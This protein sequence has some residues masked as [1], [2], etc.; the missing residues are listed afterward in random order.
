MKYLF[1]D[2]ENQGIIFVDNVRELNSVNGLT[3]KKLLIIKTNFTDINKIKNF[4]RSHPNIDVWIATED[5]SRQNIL[6]ANACGIKNVIEYPIKQEILNDILKEKNEKFLPDKEKDKNKYLAVKGLK[7]MIVDDNPLNTE[8]LE[9]TLKE[10][11]LNLVT[12]KKSK[13]A[14][15][16]I[17][18]EKF[19]LFMLDIMMPEISGFDLAE[20]IKKSKLN[21]NTPIIFISALS[22]T[23][24]KVKSYDIGSYA[25]IEKPFNVKVVRSQICSLLKAHNKI[26]KQT[27]MQNSYLAMVTHDMKGPV[28]AEMSAIKLF[29]GLYKNNLGQEQKEILEGVLSSTK[30][31]QN[32]L[33]NVLLKHKCDNGNITI[34]KS[35]N[36]YKNL[37][38]ECCD[39]IKY[40]ASERGVQ[41][42]VF[43]KSKTEYLLFDYEEIKRVI[44]NLL[45]NALKYGYKN[46]PVFLCVEDDTSML[47]TSIKNSGLGVNLKNPEDVFNKFT[48]YC[49]DQKSVNSGLGLYISKQIVEAHGGNI[50][51]ESIP[52][53]HTTVTFTL[54]AIHDA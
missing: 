19:D 37:I 27:E 18:S 50:K 1:P 8:L 49:K 51:F 34:T 36:S 43:Y 33:V 10:L 22:D 20:I 16:I 45:T 14:V 13:E 53:S 30:Y 12:C 15:K 28:Q 32:L 9:E 40:L 47:K 29:L 39:E 54:P 3:G 38:S 2:K 46:K 23:E 7:V 52:N 25:Y 17:N 24:H 5:I 4:C 42:N 26:E 6:K 21:S 41:L 44:H 31:M 35:L 48:T 11:K